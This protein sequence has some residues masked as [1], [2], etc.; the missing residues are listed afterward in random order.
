MR[1]SEFILTRLVLAALGFLVG[2][3]FLAFMHSGLLLAIIGYVAPG[4]FVSVN[5]RRRREK[6][7]RQLADALMLLTNS[8]RSG[9]GFLKGLELVAKE[10]G[11]PLSKEFNRVL[12]EVNLGATVD[13]AML[14]MGK[15]LKSEDLDIVISSYLVQKEVGGNLNEIMEKVAETIRERLRI[16]GDVRVLTA[17]GKL[18]GIIVG[19]LPFCVFF[20]LMITN[21][22]YFQSMLGEP[23]FGVM[24]S[25][26][27][28]MAGT[29]IPW[30]IVLAGGAVALQA[31][32]IFI[33][34]KIVTIK[35]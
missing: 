24:P 35:V 27:P 17:Q 28:V 21:P 11:D 15:R 10:M 5:L 30:G 23:Y 20:W 9:Y 29:Q 14:N 2:W 32:G 12:R 4:I 31:I 19:S 22:K 7:V 26:L 34:Y 8:L 13:D 1:V 16:Q 6:F 25:W 3:G 18:S 33:I